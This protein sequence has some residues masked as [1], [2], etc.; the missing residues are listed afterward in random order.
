[1]YTPLVALQGPLSASR[2]LRTLSATHL[3]TLAI[4]LATYPPF[5]LCVCTFTYV[6]VYVHVRLCVHSKRFLLPVLTPS[7]PFRTLLAALLDPY[8]DRHP[9]PPLAPHFS[10]L[11]AASPPFTGF[12]PPFPPAF[13]AILAACLASLEPS[14]HIP[15]QCTPGK[16]REAASRRSNRARG[17]QVLDADRSGG[18]DSKEFCVAM[19]KLVRT[20]CS[21]L[22]FSSVALPLFLCAP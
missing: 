1:M 7:P 11:V 5:F 22:Q 15:H 19:R 4:L 14:E 2:Y 17:A 3:D 20:Q 16:F 10:T 9:S 12:S 13:T 18:L 21:F 6:Y 8:H